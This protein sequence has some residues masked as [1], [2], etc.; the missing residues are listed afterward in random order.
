MAKYIEATVSKGFYWIEWESQLIMPRIT[1]EPLVSI[2]IVEFDVRIQWAQLTGY[3]VAIVVI[4]IMTTKAVGGGVWIP[5]PLEQAS[6]IYRWGG[7][8]IETF[9]LHPEIST[10]H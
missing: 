5:L 9:V 10:A 8:T 4:E 6:E 2:S 1:L 3:T 7:E